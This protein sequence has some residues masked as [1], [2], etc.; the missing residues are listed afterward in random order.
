M[1][2]ACGGSLYQDLVSQRPDLIKHDYFPPKFERFRIS[3]RVA[4]ERD[5]LLSRSYGGVHEVNSMH[6]QAVRALGMHLIPTARASDGVVEAVEAL[7]PLPDE[8]QYRLVG[9]HLVLVDIHAC[10]VVDIL[11]HVLVAETTLE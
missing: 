5:S 1:N 6:H 3:H 11:R 8:L 2:V 10:L 4:I 9:G 7:P